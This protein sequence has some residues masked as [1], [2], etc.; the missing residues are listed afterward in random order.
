MYKSLF[1]Q[2]TVT[3]YLAEFTGYHVNPVSHIL[4]YAKIIQYVIKNL[5][6]EFQNI[7]D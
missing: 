4:V 5:L 1:V 3:F 2:L 7:L 6:T